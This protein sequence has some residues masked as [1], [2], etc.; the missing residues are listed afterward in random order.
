MANKTDFINRVAEKQGISRTQTGEILDSMQEVLR[1]MLN[2][3]DSLT[4]KDFGR[5]DLRERAARKGKNPQTG[6]ELMIPARTVPHLSFAKTF[7]AI[8]NPATAE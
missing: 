8:F 4:I 5:F 2:E 3:G 7:R 6:A 1:E